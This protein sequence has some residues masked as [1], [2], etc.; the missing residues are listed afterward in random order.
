MKVFGLIGNPVGHSHSPILH[1]TAY[2]EYDFNARYVTFEPTLDT[3]DTALDGA[4]ALGI[5]GLNVTIPFKEDVLDYVEPDSL[6]TRIGATNTIDFS[7]SP[8]TGHNTDASGVIRAFEYHSVPLNDARVL[9]VG[10]GG[11]GKAI[12]HGVTD[13]GATVNIA[14]RTTDRAQT[15]ADS[16]DTASSH[17]L[18]ELPTIAPHC[19]ILINSTSVGMD[20]DK[21]I[22]PPNCISPDHVVMDIVY[23]PIRTTLLKSAEKNGAQTIDGAWMLLFQAAEAFE[24][25]TGKTAPVDAMNHALRERF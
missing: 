24:I 11:A 22:I 15:L 4:A 16:I 6:T 2:E 8:P 25:W 19:D 13:A 23:H 20:E 5:S 17:G 14:N 10:A 12:A 7:H 18:D 3:L 21:T 9:L 1:E